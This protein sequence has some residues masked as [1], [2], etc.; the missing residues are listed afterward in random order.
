MIS[1]CTKS[2]VVP[3]RLGNAV[4]LEGSERYL[5]RQALKPADPF[6]EVPAPQGDYLAIGCKPS[7]PELLEILADAGLGRLEEHPDITDVNRLY[8][9]NQ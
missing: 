8:R 3:E 2:D 9:D 5:V 6:F 4:Y 1:P 7:L